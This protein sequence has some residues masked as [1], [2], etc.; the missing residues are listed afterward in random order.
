[1]KVSRWK[2]YADR[3]RETSG[4]ESKKVVEEL[5]KECDGEEL[6]YATRFL[7]VGKQRF[8]KPE[9]NLGVGKKTIR[10]SVSENSSISYDEIRET[11]KDVGKLSTALGRLLSK[12]KQNTLFNDKPESMTLERLW[13]YLGNIS[14]TSTESGKKDTI[15]TMFFE[16]PEE[17]AEYISFALSGDLAM[18]IGARTVLKAASGV[19]NMD[20]EAL[21]E[22]HN[23]KPD[24]GRLL[25]KI[26]YE[27]SLP[28]IHPL[29]TRFKPMLA[30][31][32]EVPENSS[33]WAVEPKYDGARIIIRKL[34][35]S[36][37]AFTRQRIEVTDNIPE[38]HEIEW[39]ECDFVVDGE[40]VGYDPDTGENLNYQKTMTRV[41]REK[42]IEQA[43]QEVPV[44]FKLFDCIVWDGE[45]LSELTLANRYA[46]L[47]E[48]FPNVVDRYYSEV[49]EAFE[50]ANEAGHEGL[51]IKDADS[52]YKFG[53]RK[54]VWR[55]KKP[56]KDNVDLEVT[57]VQKKYK[58]DAA[59]VGALRLATRDG[60]E[61]GK[62]GTGF[63]DREAKNLWERHLNGNLVGC[64]VEVEWEELQE[65]DGEYGIR[66]ARYEGLRP[67]KNT[68]NSI[69]E[70]KK[71]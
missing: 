48:H 29:H 69:E 9:A 18:G 66:F 70:V 51:V 68:A 16:S 47:D 4:N 53:E 14:Q 15:R 7:I 56:T 5:I 35:G 71:K 19:Y 55:K 63:T 46:T 21:K 12:N 38:L 20:Y 60:T 11:E 52:Q 61:V 25:Q 37:R 64:I 49:Y 24:V 26:E 62:V 17:D 1:M 33:R 30:S 45:D 50:K 32:D 42:N 36:I 34:E 65:S 40:I 41:Q 23:L 67:D 58:E 57:E 10:K 2:D 59:H 39:P 44:E 27:G 6:Y 54:S 8:E 43:R 22:Q 3:V 28:N 31:D 13:E